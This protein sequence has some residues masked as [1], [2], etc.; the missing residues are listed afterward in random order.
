M[1]RRDTFT[2][3][4]PFFSRES[5]PF[6]RVLEKIFYLDP[7]EIAAS[8]ANQ[9]SLKQSMTTGAKTEVWDQRVSTVGDPVLQYAIG[10]IDRRNR[11]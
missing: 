10:K 1:H 4:A 8:A 6:G 3:P 11:V 9:L 5:I 2:V 7:C